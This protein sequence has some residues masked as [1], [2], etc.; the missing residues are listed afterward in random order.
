LVDENNKLTFEGGGQNVE[1]L[2]FI[3]MLLI[4]GHHLYHIG[5]VGS[6]ICRNCWVWVDFYFILTG[7]FT[8]KHFSSIQDRENP[9]SEALIYTIHKFKRFF[10]YTVIAVLLQYIIDNVDYLFTGDIHSFIR[11]F[12][13]A[14]YEILYL[15]SSGI[16]SARVAP[17]WYLSAMLIVFPMMVYLMQKVPE[18]WK[19]FAFTFPILYFG[20]K[21]V[22]TDRAWPNDMARALACMALG[23]LAYLCAEF[24]A[25][26]NVEKK[27]R[28]IILSGIEICSALFAIYV[29]VLNKDYINI[30]ELLFFIICVLMISGVTYSSCIKGEVFKFL[31]K[32]S[33]PMF[34]FHW[35]IGSLANILTD[36]LKQRFLFYYIGTLLVA[37]LALGITRFLKQNEFRTGKKRTA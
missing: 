29:S 21:G 35:G 37:M 8:Y 11:S 36:N 1:L 26:Q 7:I 22:N 3:G 14:P 32:L 5:F 27:I 9:G 30:M 16:C 13:Y 23:T 19:V 34:I 24:L 33:M 6:Y 17:I 12:I 25:K 31:G 4:M 20:H 28:K 18:F 2:R 15:S 10:G